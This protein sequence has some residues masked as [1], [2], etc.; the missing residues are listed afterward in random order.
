MQGQ[1]QMLLFKAVVLHRVPVPMKV[2]HGIGEEEAG[3]L[4]VG[5]VPVVVIL[6]LP[7]VFI[8]ML[9]GDFGDASGE[10][11]AASRQRA[12]PSISIKH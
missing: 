8:L 12:S 6:P 11:T 3:P 9:H 7:Q 4:L 1:F 10:R 2:R 5:E